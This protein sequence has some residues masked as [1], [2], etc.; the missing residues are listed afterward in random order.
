MNRNVIGKFTLTVGFHMRLI[1]GLGIEDT[2]LVAGREI[3][4]TIYA[5]LKDLSQLEKA[6]EKEEHEQWRIPLE[7]DSPVKMRIRMVNSRR[8]TVTTKA[9][10]KG[11]AGFEEQ[12]VDVTEAF[13]NHLREAATDGYKKT[14]YTSPIA[15]TNRK[16]EVDVF[17]DKVGKPHPWVKIDLEVNDIN[18][19]IPPFSLDV[20]QF[21]IESDKNTPDE[22][23][24]IRRLWDEEWLKLDS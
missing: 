5:E 17:M 22:D 21:V 8:Y 16:W 11:I 6:P 9:K 24:Q 7:K 13:F 4:Y 15:G 3:E 10:R 1:K 12:T 18:E 14:R 20:G 23:R 2:P 19:P